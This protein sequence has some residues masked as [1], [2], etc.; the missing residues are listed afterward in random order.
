MGLDDSIMQR[1]GRIIIYS[2]GMMHECSMGE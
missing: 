1:G 2:V